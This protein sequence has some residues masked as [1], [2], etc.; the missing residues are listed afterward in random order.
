MQQQICHIGVAPS[1]TP[2]LPT[3]MVFSCSPP[4]AEE[5]DLGG[6]MLRRFRGSDALLPSSV[7][8]LDIFDVDEDED[9]F[10]ASGVAAAF[11]GSKSSSKTRDERTSLEMED[12]RMV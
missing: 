10:G 12:T 8:L 4:S 5:A 1:L 6:G 2:S 3:L 7:Q 11:S 9:D